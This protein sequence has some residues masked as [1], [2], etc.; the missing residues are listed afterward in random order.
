MQMENYRQLDTEMQ[1]VIKEASS[2]GEE[3]KLEL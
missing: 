3:N 1:E 2:L